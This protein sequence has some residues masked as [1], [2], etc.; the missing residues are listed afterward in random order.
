[1]G[2]ANHYVLPVSDATK[3]NIVIGGVRVLAR[4]EDKVIFVL[5]EIVFSSWVRKTPVVERGYFL[6]LN[7]VVKQINFQA[8][9]QGKVRFSI[10]REFG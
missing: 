7:S 10:I 4:K 3:T 6:I 8:V 9:S 1:M 2:I 5:V